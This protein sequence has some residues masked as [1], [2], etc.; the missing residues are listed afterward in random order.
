MYAFRHFSFSAV[1]EPFYP[2]VTNIVSY[3]KY[4]KHN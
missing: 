4:F 3:F 1:Q 2:D